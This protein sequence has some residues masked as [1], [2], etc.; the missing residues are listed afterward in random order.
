MNLAGDGTLDYFFDQWVHGTD[1]PTLTV[2]PGVGSWQRQYQ[3]AGSIT[4]S[5]VR[6]IKKT[7]PL[8]LHFR[9][10]PL[11]FL[12]L[13]WCRGPQHTKILPPK[14]LPKKPAACCHH[15]SNMF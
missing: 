5:G 7:F 11:G 4:Q 6:R 1:I 9:R 2:H 12:R 13:F 3:I 14:T 8:Y 10:R 15:P